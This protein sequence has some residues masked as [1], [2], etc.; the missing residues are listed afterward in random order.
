MLKRGLILLILSFLFVIGC[1][2][3]GPIEVKEKKVSTPSINGPLLA[4]VNDWAIGTEDFRNQ[5][6]ALKTLFPEADIND[7]ETKKKV[8][9]EI[10]NLEI[11]AQEAESRG[12]DREKDVV[13]AIR[14]FERT[15][16][17]QKMMED[18]ERDITVTEIEIQNF[19]DSNKLDLVEPEERKIRE[20]VVPTESDARDILVNLLQ[21]ESFALL[22]S[23]RSI[24]DSKNQGGDLGYITVDP[25][26]KFQRFW[27]EAFTTEAGEVST[28][29]KGPDGYYIVKVE[30][31]RGGK[32]RPLR[33][34]RYDIEKLLRNIKLGKKREDVIFNAKQK[35]NIVVNENLLY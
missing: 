2:L 18:M 33:E 29:F 19:Y 35:L 26:K 14:N 30:D 3:Y 8:L 16:L 22:A 1:D 20:I 13:D 28:Y 24:A 34:V 31:I 7:P 23:R 9:Q 25:A 27:Q 11:L 10:V 15:L 17:A 12:I 4:Q 32:V 6:Q 21:G 5:L